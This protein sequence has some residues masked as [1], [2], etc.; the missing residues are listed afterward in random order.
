MPSALEWIS[1]LQYGQVMEYY[2]AVKM[3]KLQVHAATWM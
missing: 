3:E 2:T 1:D